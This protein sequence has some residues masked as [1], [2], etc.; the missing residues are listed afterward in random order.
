MGIIQRAAVSIRYYW[1]RTVIV[2]L[3]FTCLFTA[4]IVVFLTWV[5]SE[6]QIG[7]LQKYLGNSIAI[8][9]VMQN[10]EETPAFFTEKEISEIRSM[11]FIN[12]VNVISTASFVLKNVSPYIEDLEAYEAYRQEY[13]AAVGAFGINNAET[14]CSVYAMTDSEKMLFLREAVLNWSKE[15]PLRKLTK[16]RKSL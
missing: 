11:D 4:F 9:K 3:I 14:N 6:N 8:S 15:R 12:G 2:T 1:K 10:E 5:S 16:E 7:C 13:E